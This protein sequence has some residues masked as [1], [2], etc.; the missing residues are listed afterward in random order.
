METVEVINDDDVECEFDIGDTFDED[1]K[2]KKDHSEWKH[3][4]PVEITRSRP[5]QT[6]AFLKS[7]KMCFQKGESCN[8]S[9]NSVWRSLHPEETK[10]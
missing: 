2:K 1:T 10:L 9:G 6:E 5:R 3:R 4:T 8:P 7:N